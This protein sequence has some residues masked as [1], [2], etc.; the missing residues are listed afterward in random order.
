MCRD[1]DWLVIIDDIP[2]ILKGKKE[3]L[4]CPI[5][6]T[7]FVNSEPSSVSFYGR[8]FVKQFGHVITNHNSKILPHKNAIRSQTGN[9]WYYGKRY[10][11]ILNT[12]IK[13]TKLIST[14]CSAKQQG[15]TNH[16]KRFEFTKILQE[17]IP[18][19]DRF[20]K[21]IKWIDHKYDAIDKYKFH[22]AVENHIE[23]HVWTEKLADTFLGLAVPIYYGCPNI[24]DYFPEESIIVIDINNFEESINKIKEIIYTPGEYE[25]RLDA[26]KE[27][28]RR[29][30]EEYNLVAMVSKLIDDSEEKENKTNNKK[31]FIY[32][33]RISRLRNPMDL[34]RY[35]DFRLKNA[36]K[37]FLSKIKL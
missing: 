7:I 37:S 24:S 12:N 26:V 33:R 34:T 27:S 25:R 9:V 28:R 14:I 30:M 22:V 20:G 21:G 32:N 3:K 17:S 11:D 6:N 18:E 36:V 29:V 2:K 4:A 13:K 15:H 23:N 19:L 1:Y 5:S 10:N 8:G 35:I 31:E 16:K